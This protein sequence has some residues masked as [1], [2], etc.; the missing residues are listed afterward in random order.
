VAVIAA[1]FVTVIGLDMASGF[2]S[3]LRDAPEPEFNSD[4]YWPLKLFWCV[5]LGLLF[6]R[7]IVRSRWGG[8]RV[9]DAS[10]GRNKWFGALALIPAIYI[11]I[12]V[13]RL[14]A[15]GMLPGN[16][17]AGLLFGVMDTL[18]WVFL[19]ALSGRLEFRHYGILT[20]ATFYRWPKIETYNWS[21]DT[22]DIGNGRAVLNLK[23]RGR[24]PILPPVKIKVS[25]AKRPEVEAI[26]ARFLSEWPPEIPEPS[27]L[28][29][30][31]VKPQI[32][33]E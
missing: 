21:E 10:S 27:A 3:G 19:Y 15:T 1:F 13:W 25:Q 26:M 17:A 28:Q 31:I 4:P 12:K 29:K 7:W 9:L 8:S 16:P 22:E 32:I 20:A 2:I 11:P 18:L 5:P 24:H 14:A 6:A 30:E 23:L 33:H